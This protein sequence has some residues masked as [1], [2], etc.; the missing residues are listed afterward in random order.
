M[1]EKKKQNQIIDEEDEKN[2]AQRSNSL[3][4][5]EILE[6]EDQQT[7]LSDPG[8]EDN[9]T[10][11][12][13]KSQEGMKE[14]NIELEESKQLSHNLIE[15]EIEILVK[16]RQN[17]PIKNVIFESNVFIFNNLQIPIYLSFISPE[18]FVNKYGGK[19]SNINH[20]ENKDKVLLK[21]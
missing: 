21:T 5:S 3:V 11:S 4:I 10:T 9:L 19:D 14:K 18:D 7:V 2:N 20:S 6:E 13:K 1:K 15:D 8:S 16:V 12:N 17:G